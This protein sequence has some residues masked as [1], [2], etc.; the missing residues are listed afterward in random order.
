MYNIKSEVECRDVEA[1]LMFTG[2]KPSALI[3]VSKHHHQKTR[4]CDQV[5]HQPRQQ[6]RDKVE[7]G[8]NNLRPVMMKVFGLLCLV[9]G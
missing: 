2:G 3:R 7:G 8:G 5:N 1:E 6:D 4:T 9:V